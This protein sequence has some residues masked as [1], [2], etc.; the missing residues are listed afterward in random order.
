MAHRTLIIGVVALLLSAIAPIPSMRV[1]AVS[2]PELVELAPLRSIAKTGGRISFDGLTSRVVVK[3]REGTSRGVVDAAMGKRPAD[4]HSAA[5]IITGAGSIAPTFK[6]PVVEMR[7]EES[8]LE[9][10]SAIDLADL[11]LYLDVE[12]ESPS[13]AERLAQSLEAFDEVEFAYVQ[14]APLAPG[15]YADVAPR[16]TPAARLAGPLPAV[17]P[18]F[19]GTQF[20]LASAPGGFGVAGLRDMPGGRGEGVRILDIQYSWNINHEDLP[21][22]D[23]R[24]P[25]V[26]ERGV[27]PFPA[28]QGSHG[29]ACIGMLLGVENGFG[30]TGI[31]PDAEIGLIN[32]VDNNSDY[33]LAAAIDSA[34][35]LL[36]RGDIMQIEQQAR[37][38]NREIAA[39]PPEWEP[40][41]FDAVQ[42][43]VAKGIVVIE[44]AGNGGLKGNKA[45][46]ASLDSPE[47]GGAFDR[48]KRDS[49][50]IIVGGAVPLDAS[51]AP[52]SNYGSRLDVQGYGLYVTTLGYS[53]LYGAGDPLRSYTAIFSGTSS[54]APC[55]TGV[56]AIVQ[57]TLKA[58]GLE[59]FDSRLMRSVLVGTGSPDGSIKTQRVGPRPNASTASAG[60]LDPSVPLLTEIK[61]AAKKDRLTVDGVYFNGLNFAEVDRAVIVINGTA[62]TTTW[63][64]GYEGPYGTT[65]RLT[66]TGPELK[67]LLPSGELVFVTV[68]NG[69]G[70]E[71][72]RRIFIRK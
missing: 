59:P 58:A 61:F 60:V 8:R 21:F 57:G 15:A 9:Q 33:K 1:S 3:F 45:K 30:I 4:P 24:R 13:C 26:Y 42:R 6:R 12:T 28:D 65:T 39:L 14:P 10:E 25:F 62:V 38:I 32:P 37:G 40:A 72:P 63:S 29:T 66:A 5:G 36:E 41:G 17:T 53:D 55:V 16:I 64:A 34:T 20:Y 46:G 48:K 47:L 70:I 71:S 11:S 52:T 31:C 35:S 69:S 54:A 44:P 68:R 22:D 7:A 43:A 49:G 2:E 23:E 51:K 27:D 50:A 19:S 56:A 67:N 18:D